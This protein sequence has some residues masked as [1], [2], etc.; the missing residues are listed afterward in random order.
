MHENT[1]SGAPDRL[2]YHTPTLRDH[3]TIGELT[4]LTSSGPDFDGEGFEGSYTP[5]I[6]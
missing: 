3:G 5:N 1:P 6:S 2:P 4:L